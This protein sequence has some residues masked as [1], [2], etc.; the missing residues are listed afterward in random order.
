MQSE[1]IEPAADLAVIKWHQKLSWVG[2]LN[3]S[4]HTT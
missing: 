3:E 4:A 1:F 2:E